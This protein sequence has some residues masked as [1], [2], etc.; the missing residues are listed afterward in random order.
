MVQ[1]LTT[2][3]ATAIPEPSSL[4]LLG[5]GLAGM[6]GVIRRKLLR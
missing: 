1:S 3:Q 2:F 6:A 5:S 4:G